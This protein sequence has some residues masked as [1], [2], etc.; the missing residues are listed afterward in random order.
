MHVFLGHAFD[1]IAVMFSLT[2]IDWQFT[3]MPFGIVA[4]ALILLLDNL[5]RNSC[6]PKV[7]F[8]FT[9]KREVNLVQFVL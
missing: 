1:S 9:A 6:I 4:Y 7:F 2:Q 8:F 3:I 5:S